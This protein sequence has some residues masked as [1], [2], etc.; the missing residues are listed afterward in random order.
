MA[1]TGI[2]RLLG[3]VAVA[4]VAVGTVLLMLH[5]S[6]RSG[7]KH[8]PLL[9]GY[10]SDLFPAADLSRGSPL[11][12]LAATQTRL[13]S[14]YGQMPPHSDS[15]IWLRTFLH[16]LREIMN[17]AYRITLITAAY[18]RSVPLDVL[19]AEVQQIER[20]VVEHVAQRLILGDG[21][22]QSELLAVRLAT[23]RLCVRELALVSP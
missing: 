9:L 2:E 12:A 21:D 16:E 11:A 15:A 23:L 17:T 4:V 6:S 3:L 18:G 1:P 22:A 7:T 13:L 20:E 8:G 14:M 19:I 10:P 5:L